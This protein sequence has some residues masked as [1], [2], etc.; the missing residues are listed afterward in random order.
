MAIVE[1]KHYQFLKIWTPWINYSQP[2]QKGVISLPLK[3][4]FRQHQC[5]IPGASLP[6]LF[7]SLLS[8]LKGL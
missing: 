1:V 8:F 4:G 5:S 7:L 3:L 6:S 2:N